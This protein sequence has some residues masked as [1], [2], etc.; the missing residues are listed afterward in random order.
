MSFTVFHFIFED[1]AGNLEVRETLHLSQ[2]EQVVGYIGY[3]AEAFQGSGGLDD[4]I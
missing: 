1:G 3:L 4:I 2:T